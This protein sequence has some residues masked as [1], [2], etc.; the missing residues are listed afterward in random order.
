VAHRCKSLKFLG[1]RRICGDWSCNLQS[2]FLPESIDGSRVQ[3]DRLSFE[4]LSS[5]D[6]DDSE[7]LRTRRM[8]ETDDT[9]EASQAQNST[10]GQPVP[11]KIIKKDEPIRVTDRRF[12]MQTEAQEQKASGEYSFKPTYVEELERKLSESQR[13][14]EDVLNSYRELK[15]ES[16]AETQKAKERIQNEYNRRLGQAKSEVVKKFVDILENLER[17]LV[18]A[19][20]AGTLQ[21][22]L[23]GVQLIRNQFVAT[24]SA[25]GLKELDVIGKPFN[26]EVAE[27]IGVIDVE[28]EEQDR[29]VV[30]VVSKGYLLQEV[31]VRPARVRVGR[32]VAPVA[33]A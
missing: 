12:W 5:Y 4:L 29:C 19:S 27:A 28:N 1:L 25:L 2:L 23:E 6:V 20:E 32:S 14:L 21:N 15:A 18:A 9:Q 13:K 30:E 22:L 11:V 31:L 16:A 26:P 3:D 7:D 33:R 17:A 8:T 24:L 10:Q